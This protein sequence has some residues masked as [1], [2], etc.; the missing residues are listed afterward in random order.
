MISIQDV[1]T[2]VFEQRLRPIYVLAGEEYGI[3]QRYIRLMS[4]LFGGNITA[5]DKVSQLIDLL[6]TK[7]FIP[8]QPAVYVVR[9]D[10]EFISK[11]D[12]ELAGK[13]LN[14]KFSGVAILLYE[15]PKHL[16]KCDKFLPDNT[17]SIDTVSP[18]FLFKYLRQD[19]PSI[20]DSVIQTL[21]KH[22]TSYSRLHLICNTI[23]IDASIISK[24][25][26]L[27]EAELCK[28]FGIGD[29]SSDQAIRYATASRNFRL[30]LS[31]LYKYG[32]NLDT[33]LY[34]MLSAV[35]E[36]EKILSNSRA[37][38]NFREFSNRWTLEDTYNMF[39]HL[40]Q[41]L[42][43]LRSISSDAESVLLYLF[44]LLQFK[45]IPSVEV[46]S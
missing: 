17:V 32:D 20:P 34:S 16:A 37:E 41:A 7:H 21:L 33:F 22:V 31:L 25:S 27:A 9:Y 39:M 43:N 42:V 3:K 15:Q 2:E 10:E 14:L 36:M 38:S 18:K 40:Y 35:L 6:S 28:L 29:V 5:V 23:A 11:L 30:L 8:L 46:M 12:K 45:T 44:S 24:V 4:E 19:F 13:L 26:S 1:G